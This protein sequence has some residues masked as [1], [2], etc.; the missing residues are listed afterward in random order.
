[1]PGDEDI[2]YIKQDSKLLPE[3]TRVAMNGDEIELRMIVLAQGMA[4]R[5]SY[6][7]ILQVQILDAIRS[8]PQMKAVSLSVPVSCC[9]ASV[10]DV[11]GI[12]C[13]AAFRCQ[14]L[15]RMSVEDRA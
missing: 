5:A 11:S 8:R 15:S 10:K 2:K 3:V 13:C 4:G 1:V 7:R 6:R 14:A 12:G 9:Q